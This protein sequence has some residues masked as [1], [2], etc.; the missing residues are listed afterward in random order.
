MREL[1]RVQLANF[2]IGLARVDPPAQ[3]PPPHHYTRKHTSITDL[4]K[5]HKNAIKISE[6]VGL[7]IVFGK[8]SNYCLNRAGLKPTG[9]QGLKRNPDLILIFLVK[10]TLLQHLKP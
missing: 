3:P 6:E 7:T 5:R 2:R 10:P 4:I 9:F 8:T 1:A